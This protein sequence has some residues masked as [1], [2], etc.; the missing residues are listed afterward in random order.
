M[1]GGVE[2]ELETMFVGG[3]ARYKDSWSCRIQ[4]QLQLQIGTNGLSA[5]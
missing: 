4:G 5:Y 2:V 3:N 1:A